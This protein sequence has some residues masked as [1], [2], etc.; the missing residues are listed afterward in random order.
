MG[1]DLQCVMIIAGQGAE[2]E[3]CTWRKKTQNRY[4]NV[5]APLGVEPNTTIILTPTNPRAFSVAPSSEMSPRCK[6]SAFN[7]HHAKHE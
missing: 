3:L 1:R 2:K 7:R 5:P 6:N 4:A